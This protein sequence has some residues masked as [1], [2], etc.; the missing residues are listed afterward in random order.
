MEITTICFP[1]RDGK[2][3]LVDKKRG[4]GAG[5]LNGYGGK[6]RPPDTTIE[7]TAIREMKEEAD[8]TVI[9]SDLDKV[10]IIDFFE[11]S[12]HLFECH[13]FFCRNWQ[14]ELRETKEMAVPIPCD[15]DNLPYDRMW[16]AD[17]IW[18]PIICSGKRIRAKAY[19]AQGM[20]EVERFEYEPL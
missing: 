19:Y 10:A 1:V 11:E 3:I 17:T 6:K 15:L 4:F 16:K 9:A 12:T 2:I 7:S 14:G 5:Y 13:I 20:K 8:V 18:F